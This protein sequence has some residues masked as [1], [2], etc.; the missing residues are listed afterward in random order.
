MR[1]CLGT[2]GQR[3]RPDVFKESSNFSR[4]LYSC[5]AFLIT[6][7]QKTLGAERRGVRS[8]TQAELSQLGETGRPL[9]KTSK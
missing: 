3:D 1:R 8:V 4:F 6:R 9:L 7:L 5:G 2:P